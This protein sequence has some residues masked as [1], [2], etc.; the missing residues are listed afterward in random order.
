M[1]Y[2]RVPRPAALCRAGTAPV[3]AR[4]WQTCWMPGKLG[5]GG[6]S[7]RPSFA[8]RHARQVIAWA[9]R[10]QVGRHR[11]DGPPGSVMR[12]RRSRSLVTRLSACA[13]NRAARA[14][15]RRHLQRSSK[16]ALP[17]SR[18]GP[19]SRM[20]GPTRAVVLCPARTGPRPLP[21]ARHVSTRCYQQQREIPVG[22]I[23]L[24]DSRSCLEA[25][26][27]IIISKSIAGYR[28]RRRAAAAAPGEQRLSPDDA[29]RGLREAAPGLLSRRTPA[30][31]PASVCRTRPHA[32]TRQ[33][34]RPRPRPDGQAAK[35]VEA[36]G[37]EPADHGAGWEGRSPGPAGDR[38]PRIAEVL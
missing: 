28:R 21:A 15:S 23:P 12:D 1:Q 37:R 22:E 14:R 31:R 11:L 3:T 2:P 24:A 16:V 25:V 36:V 30:Q 26:M 27:A 20:A 10:G 32:T 17:A 35:V 34:P 7:A 8:D 18:S 19:S 33:A 5:L 29:R 4:G 9:G 13:A 6:A 38:G